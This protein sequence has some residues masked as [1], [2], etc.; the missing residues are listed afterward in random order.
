MIRDEEAGSDD[1]SANGGTSFLKFVMGLLLMLV[2]GIFLGCVNMYLSDTFRGIEDATYMFVN[3]VGLQF[4]GALFSFFFMDRVDHRRI[5]F[6]TLLPVAIL[7][8]VL[9]LN[10]KSEFVTGDDE[11]LMLQIVGMLLY[12]FAGLGITSVPWVSC[13]GLFNTRQRAVYVTVYFMVF[14]LMPV[15]ATFIRSSSSMSGDEYLYMF[16]LAGCCIVAMVLL[17]A[18]GTLKNGMVCTKGEMEAERARIRRIRASRRSARTPGS[19]AFFTSAEGILPWMLPIWMASPEPFHFLLVNL[20]S[21]SSD[22]ALTIQVAA[23]KQPVVKALVLLPE[24]C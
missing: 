17:I 6:C 2:S 23:F 22:D 18:V 20:G 15:C 3:C 13:V 16:A 4:L 21:P 24:L 10:E 1:S 7:V 14:F 11:Y 19:P 9:G 5:L 8:F 12:F